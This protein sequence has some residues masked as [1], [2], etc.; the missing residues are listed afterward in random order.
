MKYREAKDILAKQKEAQETINR[1]KGL[2]TF[3]KRI[4][5]PS[6]KELIVDLLEM[7]SEANI[8]DII[9]DYKD[10]L[11]IPRDQL[12]KG[13]SSA[14]TDLTPGKKLMIREESQKGKTPAQIAE[15]FNL[16]EEVVI[17]ALPEA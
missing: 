16:P 2:E 15:M 7:E 14:S 1:F 17:S 13:T 10:L 4:G 9:S 8:A 12:K 5:Y 11:S 3:G 6:N